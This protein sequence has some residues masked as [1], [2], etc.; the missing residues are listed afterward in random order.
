MAIP[1]PLFDR[2]RR[3]DSYTSPRISSQ[4]TIGNDGVV[5]TVS[6]SKGSLF[7]NIPS[8]LAQLCGIKK[9]GYLVNLDECVH[10]RLV[11][12]GPRAKSWNGVWTIWIRKNKNTATT[13]DVLS[14][15]N[16]L[17]SRFGI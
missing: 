7:V 8:Q 15:M 13:D 16:E 4:I 9:G 14:Y 12:G 11:H 5:R 1:S 17:R 2:F 10:L 3:D 6:E